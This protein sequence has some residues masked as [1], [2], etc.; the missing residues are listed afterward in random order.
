MIESAILIDISNLLFR[1]H[2]ANRHLRYNNKP[3]G[4]IF[5]TLKTLLMLRK[6]SPDAHLVAIFDSKGGSKRRH[7]EVDEAIKEGIITEKQRYKGQRTRG[8]EDYEAVIAQINQLW[9]F[10]PNTGIQAVRSEG[11]EAD[12]LIGSY[13]NDPSVAWLI[14]S[15]DRDFYQLVRVNVAVYNGM[16]KFT[17]NQDFISEKYGITP[18]QLIDIGALAGDTSDNIPG[19]PGVGEKTALKLIREHQT[20]EGVFKAMEAKRDSNAKMRVVEKAILDNRKVALL[21]R[22]LK[23]IDTDLTIPPLTPQ[24]GDPEVVGAFLEEEIG[25]KSLVASASDLC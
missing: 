16:K 13:A 9:D 1:C 23:K 12:D 22:S 7:K 11:I 17:V 6:A 24:R 25:A 2:Y 19:V 5:G 14:V 21:S 18:E 3:T 4:A 8:G 10:L 20:I 15:T